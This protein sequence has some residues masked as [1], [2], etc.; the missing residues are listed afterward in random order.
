[1]AESNPYALTF[2]SQPKTLVV[3]EKT[4]FAPRLLIGSVFTSIHANRLRV[5]SVTQN[6]AALNRYR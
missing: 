5:L 4:M 6:D 1:M 3:N 2:V